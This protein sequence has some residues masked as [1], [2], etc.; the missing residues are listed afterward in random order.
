MAIAE[1][2]NIT[3]TVAELHPMTAKRLR[4]SR[5]EIREEYKQAEGSPEVMDFHVA[6]RRQ[7]VLHLRGIA[8]PPG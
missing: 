2:G 4:M 7:F 1:E 3:Q 6:P 8:P 5:Q